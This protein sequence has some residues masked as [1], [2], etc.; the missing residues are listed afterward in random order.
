[1]TATEISV[2]LQHLQNSRGLT[3][4]DWA[5]ASGIPAY[6]I[7][8]YLS[9]A[10]DSPPFSAISALVKAAGGSLDEMAGISAKEKDTPQHAQD[11]IAQKE[12]SIVYLKE[13]VAKLEESVSR[14]RA[15]AEKI[16]KASSRKTVAISVMLF[17][18]GALLM[19]DLMDPRY[20]FIYRAFGVQ[21]NQ[22]MLNII[23]G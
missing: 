23:K 21:E 9:A 16:R 22:S 12:R 15:I 4:Q 10:V 19:W 18:L 14:E 8:R 11:M 17:I 6:T 5:E 7:S 1:M 13:Q 2:Y 3:Q 20:G